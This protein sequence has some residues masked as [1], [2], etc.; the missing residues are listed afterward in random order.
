MAAA[1]SDGRP[2][3]QQD[4]QDLFWRWMGAGIKLWDSSIQ[5]VLV[6]LHFEGQ[7]VRQRF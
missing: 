5:I 7:R 6:R 1:F 3:E 4:Y 2:E